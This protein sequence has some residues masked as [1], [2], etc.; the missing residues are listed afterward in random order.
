MCCPL[1]RGTWS[2]AWRGLWSCT[3]VLL[4]LCAAGAD[5]PPSE[6]LF[7]RRVQPL[8]V[9]HCWKCHG[10]EKAESGLR[11]DSRERMLTGGDRGPAIVPSDAD[12]SLLIEA[13]RYRQEDLQMPP[14]GKLTAQEI[15]F[16]AD[17]INQGAP[18]P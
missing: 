18:W 3:A 6:T 14:A 17:W 12:R 4:P 8:L 7:S 2:G 15:G 16:L 11:L 13:I 10:P 1:L 9:K 5:P